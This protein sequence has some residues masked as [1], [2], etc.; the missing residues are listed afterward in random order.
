MSGG[1]L[2]GFLSGLRASEI[3]KRIPA[4]LREGAILDIGCG[5]EAG[6]L[7]KILF[8]EKIGMERM[9]V[10]KTAVV[11]G[12]LLMRSDI[13][14]DQELP[15]SDDYFSVVTMLAVFEHIEPPLLPA[16]INEIYRILKPG[17]IFALTTPAGWTD[18]ILRLMARFGLINAA[19]FEE[20]KDVYT[21]KKI[22]EI[23]S[24]TLFGGKGHSS[25]TFEWF[26]NLRYMAEKPE[27]KISK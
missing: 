22:D 7:R 26:M 9:L 18:G 21:I 14:K 13:E 1:L 16:M 10:E 12:I 6:F 8:S 4:N 27:K 24:K 20:H 25:G 11:D 5:P 15:F 2:E 23:F 19:L 3:D 17:G